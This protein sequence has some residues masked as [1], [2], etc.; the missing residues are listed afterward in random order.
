MSDFEA[1][2]RF[3]DGKMK[4]FEGDWALTGMAESLG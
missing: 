1:L 4:A 2:L 3:S